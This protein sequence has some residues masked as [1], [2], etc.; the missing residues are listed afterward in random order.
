MIIKFLLSLIL[1]SLGIF[2][3]FGGIIL[4]GIIVENLPIYYN[5]ILNSIILAIGI[6]ISLFIGIF[7]IFFGV[8]I[9]EEIK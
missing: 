3:L 7:L 9:Q 5:Y 4:T 8:I 6:T 2:V 1:V